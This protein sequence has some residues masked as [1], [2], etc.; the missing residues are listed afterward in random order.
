MFSSGSS[1]T[2]SAVTAG[3]AASSSRLHFTPFCFP[4]IDTSTAANS[5]FSSPSSGFHSAN[6]CSTSAT[7]N[8]FVNQQQAQQ[9]TQPSFY[10]RYTNGL[11]LSI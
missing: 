7:N 2:S 6:E 9:Q 1:A 3:Q 8:L 11:Y 10:A 5:S 4:T